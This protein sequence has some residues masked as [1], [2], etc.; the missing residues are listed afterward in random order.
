MLRCLAITCL[1]LPMP[2]LA[3]ADE[4]LL[5]ALG[6]VDI[7][8]DVNAAPVWIAGYGQNRQATG[9]HDPLLAR[10]VVLRHGDQ[11]IA[12]AAVDLVGLQYPQV[13]QIRARL[14][15]FTYVIVSST[16][17]HEGPDTIGLWG[18]NPLTGGVDPE[19]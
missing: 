12:L 11:K 16:H 6:E 8:P 19:I 15:D 3:A 9:V 14:D 17:N 10:A 13:Q 18:P 4:P 5:V 2:S 7:T 1:L